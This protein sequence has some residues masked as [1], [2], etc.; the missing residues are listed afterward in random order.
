[1]VAEN[2][3]ASQNAMMDIAATLEAAHT[4]RLAS[5]RNAGAIVSIKKII[6]I[7]LNELNER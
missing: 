5:V 2:M 3:C 1:M 4:Q 7:R 6:A